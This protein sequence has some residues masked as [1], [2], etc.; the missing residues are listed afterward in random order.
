MDC[1]ENCYLVLIQTD[2]ADYD[3]MII[4][5]D[6]LDGTD[7]NFSIIDDITKPKPVSPNE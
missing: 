5:E 6:A 1:P 2:L 4:L 7:M 3:L